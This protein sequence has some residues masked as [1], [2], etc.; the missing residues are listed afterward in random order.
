MVSLFS[1]SPARQI[2]GIDAQAVEDG[3]SVIAPKWTSWVVLTLAQQ[4]RPMRVRA[5]ADRLPFVSEQ[6]VGKRLATMHADGLVTRLDDGFGAPYQLTEF[7]A[8]ASPVHQALAEWSAG[9]LP[10][11]TM[12]AGERVED[13]VRR[14]YLR[15][16]TAAIRS[17]CD[18]PM[19]LVRIC[20]AVELDTGAARQRLARL[21]ADG[22]VTRTGPRHGDPYTLTHAGAALGPVYAAVEHWNGPFATANRPSATASMAAARARN[23][24]APWPDAARTDAA[25]R[26]SPAATTS[27]FSHAA[28]AQPRV[29][30]SVTTQSFLVRTR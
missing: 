14:L 23:A 16:S 20:E 29:P 30:A 28:T 8:A 6:L 11:R 9:R 26:R 24:T 19:R 22:L 21:Q 7:G 17:L 15:H 12:A 1:P 18:G 5:V 25:T 10:P 2:S 3:L 4:D 27:L 13:A